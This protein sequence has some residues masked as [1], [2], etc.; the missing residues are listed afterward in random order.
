MKNLDALLKKTENSKQHA[1]NSLATKINQFDVADKIM[2]QLNSQQTPAEEK[3]EKMEYVTY[4]LPESFTKII[5]SIIKK[6]MREELPINKSEIV[7]LGIQMVNE[8]TI[9]Q[10]IEK[11]QN[12]KVE[13][14]RPKLK[15]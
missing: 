14:G 6:C 4:A 13:R 2:Q 15:Y 11:L 1:E 8:L 9:D 7:R 3:K 5:S 10:L 12:V